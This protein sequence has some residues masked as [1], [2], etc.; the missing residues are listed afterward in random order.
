M[1]DIDN[2]L[3]ERPDLAQFYD[4]NNGWADDFAVCTRMAEAAGSVLDLGCGTGELAA[5]LGQGRIVAGVDPAAAMLDVARVRP[6]GD[7]VTWVVGD[8]RTVRLGQRFDLIVL[9][10]HVFQVFM[11]AADQQAVIETIAAHLSEGGRFIFDSRNPARLVQSS[12]SKTESLR[13]VTHAEL[14]EIESWCESDYDPDDGVLSYEN[15]Y[16][17]LAT[18]EVFNAT[19]QIKYTS[20][21][22]IAEMIQAAG[23]VVENWMGDWQG[24]PFEPESREIIPV[25]RLA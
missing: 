23:L 5:A 24:A 25:G 12:Q 18:G 17:V 21:V 15:G 3:Y 8:A 11:T 10:G 6:G 20:K 16:R 7:E 2:G 9:T 22:V 1:G 13:Q 19:A 14:G 4:L